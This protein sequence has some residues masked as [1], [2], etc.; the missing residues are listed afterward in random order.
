MLNKNHLFIYGKNGVYNGIL[1]TLTS[2]T[3]FNSNGNN[4]DGDTIIINKNEKISETNFEDK[5]IN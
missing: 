1:N 5:L 2:S 3:K 4:S